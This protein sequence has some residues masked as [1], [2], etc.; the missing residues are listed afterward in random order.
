VG[1]LIHAPVLVGIV[2]LLRGYIPY[3]NRV[4]MHTG[5]GYSSPVDYEAQAT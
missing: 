2:R 3:Y 1:E 5:I 4:R